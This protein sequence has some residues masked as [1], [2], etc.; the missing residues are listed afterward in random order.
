MSIASLSEVTSLD[1]HSTKVFLG[2][3]APWIRVRDYSMDVPPWV[4]PWPRCALVVYLHAAPGRADAH[5][6]FFD[7]GKARCSVHNAQ[8]ASPQNRLGKSVSSPVK[9]AHEILIYQ[10]FSFFA[11]S[12]ALH[13]LLLLASLAALSRDDRDELAPG[14]LAGFRYGVTGRPLDLPL[15]YTRS[16]CTIL[17]TPALNRHN[18]LGNKLLRVIQVQIAVAR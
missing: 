7:R 9:L 13:R 14:W 5:N 15:A 11:S 16:P 1:L 8:T 4:Q 17:Q 12:R 18:R 2:F 10:V 3:H 6:R